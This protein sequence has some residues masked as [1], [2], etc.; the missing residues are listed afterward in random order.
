MTPDEIKALWGKVFPNSMMLANK[1]CI[2]TETPI[3]RFIT[4][5]ISSLTRSTS[6]TFAMDALKCG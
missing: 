1:A 2:L 3:E 6:V 5:S 4:A